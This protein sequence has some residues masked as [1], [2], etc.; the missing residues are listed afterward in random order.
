MTLA[1]T[2]V[3]TRSSDRV[4]V[5]LSRPEKRNAINQQMADELHEV[6]AELETDPRILVTLLGRMEREDSRYGLATMC[7]GVGQG[8]ALI[9]ERMP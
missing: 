5:Q 8:S 1:A 4:V 6:C 9:I 3:V 2:L 7:V